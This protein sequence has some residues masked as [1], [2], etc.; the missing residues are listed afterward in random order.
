[1]TTD[2]ACLSKMAVPD[3]AKNDNFT[4]R[5]TPSTVHIETE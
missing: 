3:I 1:M 2:L 5:K 4:F